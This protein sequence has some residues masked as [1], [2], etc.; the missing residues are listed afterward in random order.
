MA[1]VKDV[2]KQLN[3]V[4]EYEQFERHEYE[5]IISMIDD[6]CFDSSVLELDKTQKI[7]KVLRMYAKKIFKRIK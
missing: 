1:K 2:Y 4:S 7:Q 3:I 5:R 6:L